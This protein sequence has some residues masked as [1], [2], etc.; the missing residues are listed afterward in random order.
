M[1]VHRLF[2]PQTFLNKTVHTPAQSAGCYL[3]HSVIHEHSLVNM[4]CIQI[5]LVVHFKRFIW[6]DKL[7]QNFP[8]Y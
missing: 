1:C 3:C 5:T 6:A 7:V 2:V 4:Y 8:V